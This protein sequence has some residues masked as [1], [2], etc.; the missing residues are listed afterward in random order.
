MTEIIQQEGLRLQ[1]GG[2]EGAG[3]RRRLWG[4]V[5][6]VSPAAWEAGVLGLPQAAALR[7]PLQSREWVSV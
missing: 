3:D 7:S 6:L 4:L 2:E 5:S 1:A